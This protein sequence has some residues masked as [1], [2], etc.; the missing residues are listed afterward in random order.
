MAQH[1]YGLRI[2]KNVG[3]KEFFRKLGEAAVILHMLENKP[4]HTTTVNLNIFTS[5]QN[6]GKKLLTLNK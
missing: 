3:W 6:R 4:H 5:S 2:T 1:K